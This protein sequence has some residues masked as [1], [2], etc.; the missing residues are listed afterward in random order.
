MNLV[1]FMYFPAYIFLDFFLCYNQQV[2]GV[3]S[4]NFISVAIFSRL[5]PSFWLTD[6]SIGETFGMPTAQKKYMYCRNTILIHVNH[7]KK[8]MAGASKERCPYNLCQVQ[9]QNGMWPNCFPIDVDCQL[10]FVDNTTQLGDKS[11]LK[12]WFLTVSCFYH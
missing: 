7:L 3:K 11:W 12:S 2:Y 1:F 9:F 4:Y 6:W 5:G 8:N 10:I